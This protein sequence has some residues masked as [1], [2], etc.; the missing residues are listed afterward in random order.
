MELID[1][2]IDKIGYNEPFFSSDI[3]R[4]LNISDKERLLN[5]INQ[6]VNDKKIY[7]YANGIYFI[8][9]PNSTFTQD[10]LNELIQK[11]LQSKINCSS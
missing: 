3:S 1:Y 11:R 2:V 4:R 6:L 10:E 8:P 7:E 9:N 5:D